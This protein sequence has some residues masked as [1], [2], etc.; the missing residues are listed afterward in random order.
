MCPIR[1]QNLNFVGN[2][3]EIIVLKI[4]LKVEIILQVNVIELLQLVA[5]FTISSFFGTSIHKEISGFFHHMSLV[6]EFYL[7]VNSCGSYCIFILSYHLRGTDNVS[8]WTQCTSQD[9]CTYPV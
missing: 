2:K 3:E 4:I 9:S 1:C 6:I 7:T 5:T 8:S